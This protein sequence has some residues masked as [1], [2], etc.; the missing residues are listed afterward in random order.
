[1]SS[2]RWLLRLCVSYTT[3]SWKSN[4]RRVSQ[5]PGQSGKNCD[6]EWIID[7]GKASCQLE[8]GFLV[9]TRH[10]FADKE[11]NRMLRL[12]S[13]RNTPWASIGLS[14]VKVARWRARRSAT[15]GRCSTAAT[16]SLSIVVSDSLAM[17]SLAG[18]KDHTK[19]V[20]DH[21]SSLCNHSV[22]LFQAILTTKP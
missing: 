7:D 10:V 16:C 19:S 1:M 2:T 18:K 11:L 21:H 12:L 3:L 15:R 4:D 14:Q 13:R 8:R 20:D 22:R 9:C 17:P 5:A 6:E